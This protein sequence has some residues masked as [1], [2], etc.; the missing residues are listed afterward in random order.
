[1]RRVVEHLD[2]DRPL[3]RDHDAMAASVARCDALAAVEAEVG[4]LATSW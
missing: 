4:A 2:V 1:V 3:H